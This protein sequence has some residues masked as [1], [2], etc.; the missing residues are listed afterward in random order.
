MSDLYCDLDAERT[1]LGA[2]LIENGAMNVLAEMLTPK[3]FS[4]QRHQGIFDAM[5]ALYARSQPIDTVTLK[6]EMAAS[7]DG[8]YIGT[9]LDGVPRITSPDT[10]A[11]ILI[12]KAR[13]RAAR[14]FAQRFLGELEDDGME[15]EDVIERHQEQLTRLQTA[16]RDGVVSI[17]DVMPEAIRKL[18]EFATS[19]DGLL[20][21]PSGLPDIDRILCGW[22]KGNLYVIAAR[23][24]RGKSVFCAQSAVYAGFK[25]YKTLYVGMEMKP[26]QTTIRMICGHA[27]VDKYDLRKR[28]GADVSHEKSWAAINKASGQLS[29]IGVWFDQREAPTVAQIKALAKQHQAARGCDLVIVDYLQRCNLPPGQDQWVAVGN[30]AKELKSLAQALSVPIIAACQLGTDAEEKRPT[31]K[32]LAQAKQVIGAEADVI[33]FLHPEQP[34]E[35]NRQISAPEIFIIDKHRDGATADVSLSFER[36]HSRFVCLSQQVEEWRAGA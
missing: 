5:L 29:Q 18:E 27:E 1:V 28:Y 15:T 8:Q 16:R 3:H 12:D 9:A 14:L 20:G 10:W 13:R 31:K 33:A 22:Q 24:G 26:S 32:D 11:R 4:D 6:T 25:G 2:V 23:P 21:I 36:A 34:L 19:K 35:F 7:W 17:R 30:I